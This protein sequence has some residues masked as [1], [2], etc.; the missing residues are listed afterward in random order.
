MSLGKLLL[1]LLLALAVVAGVGQWWL[2]GRAEFEAQ[3]LVAQWQ[4]YGHLRY[5][6]LWVYPWG[7][8]WARGVSFEPTGFTQAALGTPLGYRIELGELRFDHLQVDDGQL[9]EIRL[10][11]KDLDLPMQDAYRFRGRMAPPAL[12]DLGYETLR[13]DGGLRLRQTPGQHLMLLDGDVA[14]ADFARL[15]FSLQLDADGRRLQM[16]P[17]QIGLRGL[18][19]DYEDRGL[20]PR[21]RQYTAALLGVTAEAAA[22]A[23]ID[24]L[25]QRSLRENWKWDEASSR[26]L[27]AFIRRP[28]RCYIELSPPGDV[29]LRNLSLYAVGDWPPLLGFR[30]TL[31]APAAVP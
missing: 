6:R 31:E 21:Y 27:R 25:N 5:D 17:D 14:A 28:Q 24:K 19:L 3:R 20:L 7:A 29:V 2:L 10:K 8:G 18:Q 23:M 9:T 15:R 12:A 26:A 1:R 22:Q 16:A 30:F 4:G 13:F 11:L